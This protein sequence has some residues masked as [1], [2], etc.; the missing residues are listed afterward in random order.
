MVSDKRKEEKD[1]IKRFAQIYLLVL[2]GVMIGTL[3]ALLFIKVGLLWGFAA[4]ILMASAMIASWL[5]RIR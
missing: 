4:F 2:A 5:A 3:L 1:M